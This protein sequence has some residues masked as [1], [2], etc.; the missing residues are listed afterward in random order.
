[1][2]NIIDKWQARHADALLTQAMRETQD[3]APLLNLRSVLGYLFAG[4]FVATAYL[5]MGLGVFIIY[6]SFFDWGPAILGLILITFGYFL[7]PAKIKNKDKT[8]RREDLPQLFALLDE[9]AEWVGTEPPKGVHIDRECN[10]YMTEFRRPHEW[11]LGIGLPFWAA[12]TG[13]Q[14]VA[15]LAH[16]LAHKVNNDPLRS[17]I[18]REAQEVLMNWHE[19]FYIDEVTSFEMAA[20]TRAGAP[21]TQ[22][23]GMFLVERLYGLLMRFVFHE[24]QRAEYRADALAVSVAG[25]EAVIDMLELL[26]RV[27]PAYR[28]VRDLYPYRSEQTGRIFDHMAKT[29]ATRDQDTR[30]RYFQLAAQ[31][32]RRV[33]GSHPPT[34][35]RIEFVGALSEPDAILVPKTDFALIDAELEP[36]K[37][38]EGQRLMQELFDAEVNN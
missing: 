28:A 15:L 30:R 35:M 24:S 12:L 26:T 8:Y 10:A 38:K 32:K 25:R 21:G 11:V 6:A 20:G 18:Y 31:E 29:L 33:D 7:K 4:T 17:G 22:L 34:T 19:T 13:P 27:E 37:H 14:K 3:A 23:I 36:I 5:I 2:R 9:I 16:E 1:M